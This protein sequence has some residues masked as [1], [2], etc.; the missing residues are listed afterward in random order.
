MTPATPSRQD[1]QRPPKRPVDDRLLRWIGRLFS[2]ATWVGLGA[3]GSYILLRATGATFKNFEQWQALLA[4]RSMA[5]ASTWIANVGIG[6]HFLMGAVLVLAW[7]ILLSAR[8]RARH[9]AV[10][11][12]TGRV[13]RR[14]RIWR[15]ASAWPRMASAGQSTT[16][17]CT[18]SSFPTC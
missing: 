6:L 12:W 7:P 17:S 9:R 4:G 15:A 5:T 18:C 13:Y 2:I 8:I 11:R 10:H 14:G 1:A 16:R 3:F